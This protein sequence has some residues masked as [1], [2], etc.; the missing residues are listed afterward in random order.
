MHFVGPFLE[1]F[2]LGGGE[3]V[4][5]DYRAVVDKKSNLIL[6]ELGGSSHF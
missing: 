3:Y 2:R 6:T 5:E 1:L 4:S